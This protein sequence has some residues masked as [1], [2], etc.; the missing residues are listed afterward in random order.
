MKT[1]P[2]ILIASAVVLT[3]SACAA[4]GPESQTA[5][6]AGLISQFLLGLWHGIIAPVTRLV[7]IGYWL[8]PHLIP[9]NIRL[10]ETRAVSVVY[11]IGF[12]LGLAGGPSFATSR[13]R[14]R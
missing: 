4:G 10:Y 6:H 1:L 3:L 5:A 8:L 14:G 9:W 13:W 7:E 2:K 11:D 12:Y